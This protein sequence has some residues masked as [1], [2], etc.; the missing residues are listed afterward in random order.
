MRPFLA[1][2]TGVLALCAAACSPPESTAETGFTAPDR[3]AGE[4]APLTAACDG[5]DPTSCLLPWPSSVFTAVDAASPTGVRVHVDKASLDSDDDPASVNRADG[6]SRITPL[7]TGFEASLADPPDA[8][9]LQLFLVQPGLPGSGEPVPV[10]LEIHPSKDE[11]G[12]TLLVA[13]PYRALAPNAEYL[14]VVTDSLRPEGGGTLAP[15]RAAKVALGLEKPA[16]QVDADLYGH[17]APARALLAKAGIDPAHVVR[18]W[19]FTTRSAGDATRRLLAMRDAARA[20]VAAG[21]TQVI[22]DVVKPGDGDIAAIVEGRLSGLPSFAMEE[23]LSLDADGLPTPNGTREAAFRVEIPKGSGDYPFLMFGHGTG[24]SFRDSAFDAELGAEGIG[25]VGFNLYGWTNDETLDTFV[26]MTRMFV[27]SEHSTA[28]LMQAL[29]E[30][31]ALQ[32]AMDGVLGDALAAPTLLGAPNPA[33]GRRPDGSVPLWAGGSLGGTMGLV[34]ASADPDMG[35]AVL[36]VPGAGW[37]HFVP[38]SSVYTT[39]AALLK[40]NFDSDLSLL[41]AFL[42]SQSNWDDVDGAVWGEA[43]AGRKTVFLVQESIGDPILPNI[44]S[45]NVALAVDAV[46]VGAVLVPIPGVEPAK[47]AAVTESALTQYHVPDPGALEIHGFA[48]RDTPAGKAAR[49]QIRTFVKSA[50]MGNPETVVP[51]G[52]A[53]GSC[54]FSE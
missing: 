9:G 13:K 18:L 38:L 23:G 17:H 27:G 28:F 8:A 25:K 41:Q 24:G 42:M 39:M 20:A 51:P 12:R 34:Y 44:G 53:G 5:M 52:C 2:A 29:A 30:G 35:A 15:E 32:A 46:Q 21:D 19:D 6:F 37:T 14:A 26:R 16:S 36:N 40:T 54:D 43:R 7:L 50:L 47:A 4:R 45:E 33:A 10:R 22:L 3:E 11:E 48:A 1:F 31:A 49:D